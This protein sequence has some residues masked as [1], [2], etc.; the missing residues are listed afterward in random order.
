MFVKT[1][2]LKSFDIKELLNEAQKAVD[3]LNKIRQM[4]TGLLGDALVSIES[5]VSMTSQSNN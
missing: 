1:P 3:V 4:R 2:Y 5:E